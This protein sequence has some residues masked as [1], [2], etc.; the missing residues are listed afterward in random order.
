MPAHAESRQRRRPPRMRT[1]CPVTYAQNVSLPVY[2][3]RRAHRPG[4]MIIDGGGGRIFR[5][6]RQRIRRTQQHRPTRNRAPGGLWFRDCSGAAAKR[7]HRVRVEARGRT[8]INRVSIGARGPLDVSG[9][10]L[11]AEQDRDEPADAGPGIRTQRPVADCL[12]RDDLRH[13]RG[14][15]SGDQPQLNL[16]SVERTEPNRERAR[17]IQPQ[18]EGIPVREP[19]PDLADDVGRCGD[20][21]RSDGGPG[22]LPDCR[23]RDRGAGPFDY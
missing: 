19:R 15:G 6:V 18:V 5:R 3:H 9:S 11:L 20:R 10:F 4:R 2:A 13:G 14:S 8:K 16:V 1:R 17:S 7:V 23:L 21:Q 12:H 22:I